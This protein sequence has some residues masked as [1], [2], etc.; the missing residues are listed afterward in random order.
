MAS[1]KAQLEI[2]RWIENYEGRE[3]QT[4]ASQRRCEAESHGG[5]WRKSVKSSAGDDESGYGCLRFPVTVGGPV[6]GL[7][8]AC[9][10]EYSDE[11]KK[12]PL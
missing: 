6:T 9:E 2:E 4:T 7:R 3:G 1:R 10:R 8:E 5:W 11:S 12:H